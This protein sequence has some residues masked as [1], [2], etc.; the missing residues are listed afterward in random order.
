MDVISGV[1]QS[2]NEEH[3][4]AVSSQISEQLGHLFDMFGFSS[5]LATA[6]IAVL[7]SWRSLSTSRPHYD[8]RYRKVS[9]IVKVVVWRSWYPEALRSRGRR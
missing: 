3:T 6:R 1:R 2:E 9:G 7:T 4:I 8:D 5:S